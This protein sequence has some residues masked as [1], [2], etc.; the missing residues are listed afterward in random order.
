MCIV[1]GRSKTVLPLVVFI[2]LAADLSLG[3]TWYLSPTGSDSSGD[4]SWAN[5]W[6]ELEVAIAKPQIQSGDEVVLLDGVYNYGAD[7]QSIARYFSPSNPV[8]IRADNPLGAVIE[9]AGDPPGGN[10]DIEG[11]GIWNASGVVLDG[12]EIRHSGDNAL[13][14]GVNAS[15]ITIRNCKIHDAGTGGDAIKINGSHHIVIENCEVYDPGHRHGVATWQENIDFMGSTDCVVRYCLLYHTARGGDAMLY[16]KGDSSGVVFESNVLMNQGPD[17][18][19]PPVTLGGT[20]HSQPSQ[21]IDDGS[22]GDDGPPPEPDP[23]EYSCSNIIFRNNLVM[24]ST[25]G[26]VAFTACENG[27]VVNNVFYDCAGGGVWFLSQTNAMRTSRDCHVH[28]NVFYDPDGDLGGLYRRGL[29]ANYQP[30][31]VY[32]FSASNNLFYNAG[33]AIPSTGFL[34]ANAEVGGVVAD[35][36]FV[37]PGAGGGDL[38]AIA[39]NYWLLPGSPAV[40]AGTDMSGSPY[41]EVL[42]DFDG[43]SRTG[44]PHDIG[45]FESTVF[46]DLD[47][48]GDVDLTD[49]ELL[50]SAQ[51]GPGQS[52]ANPLADYDGDDDCDMKEFQ[53]FTENFTGSQ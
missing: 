17:A 25:R 22:I 26:S 38:L 53:I 52:T 14:I 32:S 15:Y 20:F 23:N 47:H 44:G 33:S 28:N 3:A 29:T 36:G 46:G 5:P 6:Y 49:L 21:M 27:W 2:C 11:V 12:L 24:R 7:K 43:I 9:G 45:M 4:G 48:D 30:M 41:P 31:V 8:V 19:F 51:A 10:S 35:P 1:I 40:D 16:A 42:M 13:H 50:V 18:W 34:D 37:S 39:H